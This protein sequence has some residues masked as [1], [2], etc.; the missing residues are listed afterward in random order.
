VVAD[1]ITVQL[2]RD[3]AL[4]LF[5]WLARTTSSGM[6]APLVDQ[7]EQRA[8]WDLESVLESLLSEPSQADYVQRIATAR[9]RVRDNDRESRASSSEALST[10]QAFLAMTDY[11]WRYAQNAGDD[12]ITLLGDTDIEADGGPTDAAAWD[13]WLA[14]VRHILAGQPPRIDR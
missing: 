8:L 4:V 1:H 3:Q 13:D 9:D 5:D 10:R 14:S 12:L 7:A 11:I 2:T 6:P